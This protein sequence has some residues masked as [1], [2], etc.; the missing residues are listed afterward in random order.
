MCA[1]DMSY[2]LNE[3]PGCFWFVGSAPEQAEE[4]PHHKSCFTIDERSLLVGATVM[5]KVVEQVL[6]KS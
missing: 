1:E 5:F 4:V 2:F 3:R 6:I